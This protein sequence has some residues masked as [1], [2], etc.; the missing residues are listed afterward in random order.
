MD[1][2]WRNDTQF[3]IFI[4]AEINEAAGILTISLWGRSDGRTTIMTGP[5]ISDWQE[6]GMAQWQYD[7][8][9][10]NGAVRQ[11]VHARNG[12]L[13]TI[14]R[15]VQ[16]VDGQLLHKD[17]VT[18]HY[19]PWPQVTLFGTGIVPPPGVMIIGQPSQRFPLFKEP[20]R[21]F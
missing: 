1:L 5:L 17:I 13:A 18:T 8:S 14:G 6:S 19:A 20:M 2:R 10:P 3:D 21:M 11:L 7:P 9:L 4:A 16:S 12:M 15:V